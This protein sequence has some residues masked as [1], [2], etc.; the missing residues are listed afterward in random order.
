M[1]RKSDASSSLAADA[2]AQQDGLFEVEGIENFQLPAAIITRIA[3]SSLPDDTKM[4]KDATTALVKAATVFIN[5]ISATS[6]DIALS[7]ARKNINGLDVI[8]AMQL[9]ALPDFAPL[10]ERELKIF[11]QDAKE[12]KKSGT[13]GASRRKSAAGAAG[14]SSTA[15]AAPKTTPHP[16]AAPSTV[17]TEDIEMSAEEP[18]QLG[19]GAPS[20]HA[21]TE[22]ADAVS[23]SKIIDTDQEEVDESGDEAEPVEEE[24]EADEEAEEDTGARE[25]EDED[26]DEQGSQDGM[27]VDAGLGAVASDA[28]SEEE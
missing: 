21:E 2:Q 9:C 8:N 18:D 1:P 22:L 17:E 13:K 4:A 10:L 19:S 16:S 23:R 14:S 11:Q 6:Q 24:E 25:D 7:K 5:Y 27:E 3:K 12:S 15:N 28:E 20:S 26:V